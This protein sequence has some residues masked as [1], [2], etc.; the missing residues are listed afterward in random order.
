MIKID[1]RLC[2]GMIILGALG[3]YSNEEMIKDKHLQYIA[4]TL[5]KRHF[6]IKNGSA[7]DRLIRN[8]LE[9]QKHKA[10]WEL[11][12]HIS[13]NA[14][15]NACTKFN[16]KNYITVT[17]LIFAIIK[18]SPDV[19]KFYGFT[20]KKL[21]EYYDSSAYKAQ[22]TFASMRVASTLLEML[23]FEIAH[24]YVKLDKMTKQIEDIK[25]V[26]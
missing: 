2:V 26:S 23:D 10:I 16:D 3:Y 24:Y 7:K 5:R 4:K 20:D 12:A 17:S 19:Q 21:K 14:W 22:H 18:K 1:K 15:N 8:V 25:N 11:H 9:I 13:D 6:D